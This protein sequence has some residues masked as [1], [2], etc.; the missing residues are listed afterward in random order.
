M[1]AQINKPQVQVPAHLYEDYVL[2]AQLAPVVLFKL[3]YNQMVYQTIASKVQVNFSKNR[4]M[5]ILQIGNQLLLPTVF[6]L[7]HHNLVLIAWFVMLM[8]QL[9]LMF[10]QHQG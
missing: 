1:F 8:H 6:L 7:S 9:T 4:I 2:H 5:I 3:E 10:Q